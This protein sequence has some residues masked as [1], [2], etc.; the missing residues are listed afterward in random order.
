MRQRRILIVPVAA[1]TAS[2]AVALVAGSHASPGRGCTTGGWAVTSGSFPLGT[3]QGP[4]IGLSSTRT[5]WRLG[6]QTG[7]QPGL[8]G[9]VQ[10]NA[11]V[12]V[13]HA[14]AG[15]RPV[16]R[17]S[18]DGFSMRL[19]GSAHAQHVDFK[20]PCATRLSF[21]F[22]GGGVFLGSHA[23]PGPTFELRRPPGTGIA[24]RIVAGP[25]CPLVTSGCPSWEPAR[26]TVRIET[27]PASR[28]SAAGTPV[29]SVVSDANGS[30]A[31]DLA[32]GDY[33]LYA[34]P[35]MPRPPTPSGSTTSRAVPV[36][37]E[38]GVVSEVTL[39]FD[40]GTR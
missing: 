16:L 35:A 33:L 34:E 23:A 20:A 21:A 26:G 4:S 24:G 19:A 27:A 5:G 17:R 39:V 37:V 10:A 2:V 8:A 11:R 9:A 3:V 18:A 32:P 28:L 14:T 29:K 12:V 6:L 25:T 31:S 15:L 1:L 38:A 22:K 36:R 7:G 30:F 13:I 40:T